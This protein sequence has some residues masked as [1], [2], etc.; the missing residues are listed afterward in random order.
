M[1]RIVMIG[2]ALALAACGK[3][4]GTKMGTYFVPRASLS[5]LGDVKVVGTHDSGLIVETPTTNESRPAAPE[6][7][8]ASVLT[9]GR[10]RYGYGFDCMAQK[11]ADLRRPSRAW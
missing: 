11:V 3:S 1:K 5:A 9:S 10:R 7:P 4:G 6:A 8:R 2:A